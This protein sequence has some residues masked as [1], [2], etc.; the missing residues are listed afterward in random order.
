MN[1]WYLLI[2]DFTLIICIIWLV[3]LLSLAA[4]CLTLLNAWLVSISPSCLCLLHPCS[5]SVTVMCQSACLAS[6]LACSLTLTYYYTKPWIFMKTSNIN[7]LLCQVPGHV[8]EFVWYSLVTL[9]L[10]WCSDTII[11]LLSN[12]KLM[13]HFVFQLVIW[14]FSMF[15]RI[16]AIGLSWTPFHSFHS[17]TSIII[18]PSYLS[19]SCT[20]FDDLALCCCLWVFMLIGKFADFSLLLFFFINGDLYMSIG[21]IITSTWNVLI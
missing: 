6:L 15:V 3:I 7:Q 11:R 8:L 1:I 14:L 9:E 12:F 10:S 5:S 16:Y 17:I 13:I 21:T 20:S 2:I 4:S 19:T 18:Q